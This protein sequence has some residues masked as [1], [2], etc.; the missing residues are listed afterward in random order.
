MLDRLLT[1]VQSTG[2]TLPILGRFPILWQ[3]DPPSIQ[4]PQGQFVA[5]CIVLRW[6]P[7]ALLS[8]SGHAH[9]SHQLFAAVS[10]RGGL[11]ILRVAKAA[12]NSNTAQPSRLDSLDSLNILSG[13]AQGM[14]IHPPSTPDHAH[15]LHSLVIN[16][17]T[18]HN[19]YK[20]HLSSTQNQAGRVPPRVVYPGHLV[21]HL[22]PREGTDSSHSSSKI[23]PRPRAQ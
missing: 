13:W 17:A 12:R 7:L 1:T 6:E 8:N 5:N 21:Y 4:L 19:T 9:T 15:I 22:Y 2:S 16:V 23:N 14:E 20:Q 10:S 18:Q 11:V 3:V